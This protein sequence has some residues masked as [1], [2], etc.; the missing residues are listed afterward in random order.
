MIGYK[1]TQRP[2]DN[3]WRKWI[4]YFSTWRIIAIV[5]I[6]NFTLKF[7]T[8]AKYFIYGALVIYEIFYLVKYK[9]TFKCC[10]RFIFI[11]QEAIIICVYSIYTFKDQYLSDYDID[12]IALFLVFVLEVLLFLPKLYRYCK[13]DGE[14]EEEGEAVNPEQRARVRRQNSFGD[15]D[16]GELS[17]DKLANSNVG[18]PR[19]GRGRR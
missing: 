11:L 2:E 17:H 18:S 12:I 19:R 1:C 7:D 3:I 15:V 10:E 14:D 4:E 16:A 9:F 6:A 5:L 8:L 13:S